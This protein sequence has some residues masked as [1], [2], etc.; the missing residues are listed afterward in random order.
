MSTESKTTDI[1]RIIPE[2]YEGHALTFL[3]I[4]GKPMVIAREVGRAL[5]YAEDG[6]AFV[7]MLREWSDDLRPGEHLVK[8]DGER[9]A[10]LKARLGSDSLPSR[11]ASL[12]LLT[13]SGLIRACMF[14]GGPVAVRFRDWAQGVLLRAVKGETINGQTEDPAV[15]KSRELRALA[16]RAE[17]QGDRERAKELIRTAADLFLGPRTAPAAEVVHAA[18]LSTSDID[19]FFTA[20]GA[21]GGQVM[22][23]SEAVEFCV[24]REL[25]KAQITSPTQR[26][27]STQMGSLLRHRIGPTVGGRKLCA[28]RRSG[29]T[30]YWLEGARS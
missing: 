5:G 12:L 16:T 24:S 22:S 27:R 8:V 1:L 11:T 20:W 4:E 17:K 15:T 25:L 29:T 3:E 13:D 28:R 21:V 10:W 23:P 9:L 18:A 2:V 6:H 19:A 14:A 7:S 30:M 26:G